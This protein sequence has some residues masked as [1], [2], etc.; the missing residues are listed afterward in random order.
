MKRSRVA[1]ALAGTALLIAPF[2]PTALVDAGSQS[3]TQ[4]TATFTGSAPVPGIPACDASGKCV[5]TVTVGSAVTGDLQGTASSVAA[6]MFDSVTHAYLIMQY[7]LFTG[8]VEGCGDGSLI[9]RLPEVRL[10]Q[11]IVK[12]RVDVLPDTG[13]NELTGLFG[14]GTYTAVQDAAGLYTTT[15]SLTLHCPGK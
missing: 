12:G 11:T 2:V 6:L 3:K 7:S 1:T 15:M 10:E 13:T 9:M 8:T 4:L 5:T 14:G